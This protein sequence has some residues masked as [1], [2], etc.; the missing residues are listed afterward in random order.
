MKYLNEY[1]PGENFSGIYLVKTTTT[2]LTKAGK[3]YYGLTLQ[4]KNGTMEAKIWNTDAAE[5]KPFKALDYVSAA[6]TCVDF[7]GTVQAH[8]T[9]IRVAQ[10]SEYNVGDYIPVTPADVKTLSSQLDKTIE[11]IEDPHLHELC[12]NLFIKNTE[13]RAKFESWSAAKTVHHACMGGLLHHTISVT[14]ICAFLCQQYP[15]LNR[16]LLLTAA[17]CHDIGKTRELTQFPENILSDVG[18]YVGH[19]VMSYEMLTREIDKIADFPEELKAQLQHCILAHHGELEF[20]SPK[21]PMISEAFALAYADLIDSK[22]E[23]L[24]SALENAAPDAWTPY[25]KWLENYV[26]PTYHA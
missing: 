15:W 17:L 2:A 21:K 8:L 5:I 25:N 24:R 20:G 23:I 12:E 22:M 4:D 26:H 9:Q 1:K 18:Y 11:V 7:A 6:G 10:P 16:D 3:P 19:V 13:F 14:S